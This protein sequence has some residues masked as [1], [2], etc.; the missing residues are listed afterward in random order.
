[1]HL[2]K[3]ILVWFNNMTKVKSK[4]TDSVFTMRSIN[5]SLKSAPEKVKKTALLKINHKITA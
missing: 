3:K 4:S 5:V 2:G 1:M